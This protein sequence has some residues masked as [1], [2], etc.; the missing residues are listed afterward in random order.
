MT[1]IWLTRCIK[2]DVINKSGVSKNILSVGDP[3]SDC[4]FS[5]NGLGCS[6]DAGSA[7]SS[8]VLLQPHLSQGLALMIVLLPGNHR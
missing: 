1:G 6:Q 7:S 2:N 4:Y 3:C 5:V 8:L